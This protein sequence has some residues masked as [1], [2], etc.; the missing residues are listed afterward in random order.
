MDQRLTELTKVITIDDSGDGRKQVTVNG[1]LYAQEYQAKGIRLWSDGSTA[2]LRITLLDDPSKMIRFEQQ[3]NKLL[4]LGHQPNGPG[5]YHLEIAENSSGGD[6]S[7]INFYDSKGKQH[8]V[9][10]D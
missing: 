7:F 8:G 3:G 5:H 10:N 9:L 2:G 1:V 6:A 4:M